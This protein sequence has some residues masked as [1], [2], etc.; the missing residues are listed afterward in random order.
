MIGHSDSVRVLVDAGA[1]LEITCVCAGHHA[2]FVVR[3]LMISLRASVFVCMLFLLVWK[4][5]MC[6]AQRANA[7]S[8]L[9]FVDQV[10]NRN[11]ISIGLT[12]RNQN[13]RFI[14][15]CGVIFGRRDGPC[16][17]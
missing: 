3:F 1:D 12:C 17:E 13:S 6:D 15:L 11:N 7:E 2:L 8:Y 16:T 5:V 10:S 9:Y 14:F 4:F